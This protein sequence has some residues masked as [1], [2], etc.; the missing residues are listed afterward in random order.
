MRRVTL[1]TS[2]EIQAYLETIDTDP[3][4]QQHFYPLLL[5]HAGRKVT[6]QQLAELLSLA[7]WQFAQ[8]IGGS[9]GM[10]L[11]YILTDNYL[12][13]LCSDEDIVTEASLSIHSALDALSRNE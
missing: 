4:L 2:E 1:R 11:I 12:R 7:I 6:A 8:K 9:I 10:V 5:A 3:T 13:A